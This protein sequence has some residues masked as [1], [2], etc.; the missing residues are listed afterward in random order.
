MT[1]VIAHFENEDDNLSDWSFSKFHWLTKIQSY[2]ESNVKRI[3]EIDPGQVGEN[4]ST[5]CRDY[6]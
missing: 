5:A 1:E 6:C 4:A 2:N 3:Y